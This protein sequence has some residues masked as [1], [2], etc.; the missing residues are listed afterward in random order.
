MICNDGTHSHKRS[1]V[2]RTNQLISISLPA[3]E[4]AGGDQLMSRAERECRACAEVVMCAAYLRS[5]N[6]RYQQSADYH[7]S[8]S[9]L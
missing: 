2:P 9:R 3:E 8:Q 6:G 7:H 1:P 4:R 5:D